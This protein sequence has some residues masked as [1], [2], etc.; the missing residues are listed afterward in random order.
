MDQ[1]RESSHYRD[2]IFADQPE[3]G[4]AV[5]A[6]VPVAMHAKTL[7]LVP[8]RKENVDTDLRRQFHRLAKRWKADSMFSSSSHDR[9]FHPSYQ[10]IIG[11]GKEALPLIL[12]DLRAG[13]ADW[14]WA[15]QCITG[16]DPV[17]KSAWGN[18]QKAK[19]AWLNWASKNT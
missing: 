14:F 5:Q 3:Q 2:E 16:K 1:F 18:F 13:E 17:R 12:E 6:L 10:R 15:L 9:Y 7:R 8:T 11:L 19:A 4:Y